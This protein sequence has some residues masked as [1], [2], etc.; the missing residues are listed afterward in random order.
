[1]PPPWSFRLGGGPTC[2][3][4]VSKMSRQR[5]SDNNDDDDEEDHDD[6]HDDEDDDHDETE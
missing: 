2:R 1:M 3:G 6:D 4:P 5:L